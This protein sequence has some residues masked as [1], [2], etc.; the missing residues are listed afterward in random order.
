MYMYACVRLIKGGI[1]AGRSIEVAYEQT[2]R[3]IQA[4]NHEDIDMSSNV[5]ELSP[6]IA[7]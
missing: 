3:Y 6:S 7:T 4:K 2:R 5:R 1:V